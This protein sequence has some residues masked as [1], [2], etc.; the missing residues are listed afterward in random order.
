MAVFEAWFEAPSADRLESFSRPNP[1]PSEFHYAKIEGV[2]VGLINHDHQSASPLVL[3]FAGFFGKLRVGRID[4]PGW[5]DSS[6]GTVN[7]TTGT[8]T[9]TGSKAAAVAGSYAAAA[10]GTDA[11]ARNRCHSRE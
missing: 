3:G 2:T 7:T 6:A 5:S 10:T 11:A 1:M 8:H 4:W 9:L